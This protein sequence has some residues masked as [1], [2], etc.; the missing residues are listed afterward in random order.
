MPTAGVLP[1]YMR[2]CIGSPG[3]PPSGKARH[4]RVMAAEQGVS[5]AQLLDAWTH[6]AR[7]MELPFRVMY[8]QHPGVVGGW[9]SRELTLRVFAAAAWGRLY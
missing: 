6:R 9:H 3:C 4:M 1:V 2:L 5:L 8:E 7:I